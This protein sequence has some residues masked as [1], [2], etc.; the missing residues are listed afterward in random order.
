M[1]NVTQVFVSSTWLDLQAERAAVESALDKLP[2]FKFIGME[3]FGSDD[4]TTRAVSLAEVDESG[5]YLGIIGGRYGSGITADEY[6]RAHELGLFCLLYFKKD[7]AVTDAQ[8]DAEPEKQ[9]QLAALK[10]ELRKRH[11]IVEFER[12]EDLALAVLADLHKFAQR[13]RAPGSIVAATND[14]YG[15][16]QTGLAIRHAR[17]SLRPGRRGQDFPAEA[18]GATRRGGTR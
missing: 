16:R 1:S 5:L 7:S 14:E 9:A 12:P 13:R 15:Y 17:R 10:T 18:S 11:L 6:N 4:A 8:R 3:H 2:D